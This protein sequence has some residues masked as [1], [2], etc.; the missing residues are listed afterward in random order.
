MTLLRPE[1]SAPRSSPSRR[2]SRSKKRTQRASHSR[3][4]S[5]SQSFLQRPWSIKDRKLAAILAVNVVG[6]SRLVGVDEASTLERVK[7]HRI[8][9]AEPLIVEHHGRVV[10]LTGDDLLLEFASAVDAVECAVAIQS[11][12]PTREA[13]D[14]KERRIRFRIGI[15]IGDIVP[16]YEPI[17]LFGERS[18]ED[19][20]ERAKSP[21]PTRAANWLSQ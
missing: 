12:W 5:I 7:A 19:Y 10:K 17:T 20:E 11:E 2:A 1:P 13:H 4:A 6:Y 16:G 9:L 8:E 3:P 21:P 18:R 14:P 15:N